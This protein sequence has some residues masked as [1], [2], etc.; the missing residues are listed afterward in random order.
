MGNESSFVKKKNSKLNFIIVKLFVV[1]I[2]L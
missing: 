2:S 1:I